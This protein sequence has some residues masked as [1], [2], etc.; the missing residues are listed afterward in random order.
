MGTNISNLNALCQEAHKRTRFETSRQIYKVLLLGCGHVGKTT[1]FKQLTKIYGRGLQDYQFGS[2]AKHIQ[3]SVVV[4]M[5]NILNTFK[6]PYNDEFTSALP[7]EL[8][9]AAKEVS[10]LSPEQPLFAVVDE[11][12][13]LWEN[14]AIKDAYFRRDTLGISPSAQYFFDDYDRVA[15]RHYRPSERDIIMAYIPTTGI[16]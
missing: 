6:T 12:K 16:V 3:A 15:A 8:L 4:Q 14:I 5:K 10:N 2:A 13:L 9:R 1:I 11:I 7:Q